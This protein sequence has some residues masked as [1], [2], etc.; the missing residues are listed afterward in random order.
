METLNIYILYS[1][2]LHFSHSSSG[3]CRTFP[4][5]II[6]PHQGFYTCEALTAI[7]ESTIQSITEYARYVCC[8]P[9]CFLFSELLYV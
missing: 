6:T 9:C 8:I 7:A 1:S 2:F 3:V 5:V 4:N